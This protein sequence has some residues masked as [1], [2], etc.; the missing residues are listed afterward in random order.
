MRLTSTEL[1]E[2]SRLLAYQQEEGRL[3]EEDEARLRALLAKER[4]STRSM[5]RSELIRFGRLVVGLW[6]VRR[7]SRQ[8]AGGEEQLGVA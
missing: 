1:E 8:V 4:P 2:V 6:L 7:A 3:A 5:R